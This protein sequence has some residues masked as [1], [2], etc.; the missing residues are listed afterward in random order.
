MDD[1]AL[2]HRREELA[3][4]VLGPLVLGGP[5]LPV[6]PVGARLGI[7]LGTE[8]HIAD[9]DLKDRIET[10]RLRRA[11]LFAPVDVLPGF[12]ASDWAMIVAL[13]D[14]VQATNHHLGGPLTRSRYARLFGNVGWLCDRIPL[15]RTIEEVIARHATFAKVFDIV[16]I[17]SR[18]S[19]WTGRASFRGSPPPSRL[20]A[21]PKLRQ[22]RVEETRVPLAEMPVG[23]AGARP[24]EHAVLLTRWIHRTPLTDL[25]C[26]SRRWPVFAWS[27]PTLALVAIPPGRALAFRA[28]I[29]APSSVVLAAL[30][31]ATAAISPAYDE[32]RRLAKCFTDEARAGFEAQLEY[33]T[34]HACAQL[35]AGR[36]A[37]R[38]G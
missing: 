20:L 32:A 18:V 11:R 2:A 21:L 5:L 9:S 17:D 15:P 28:L 23:C 8:P 4:H 6:R 35:G 16:R 13:N 7:R 27:Q 31:R 12:D 25:A 26:A 33:D 29:R 24:E 38:V 10:A 1:A 3:H 14:L 34:A 19:W 36:G 37:R 22:V 30:E